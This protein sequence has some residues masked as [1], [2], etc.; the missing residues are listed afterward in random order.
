MGNDLENF[1]TSDSA[2]KMI[3]FVSD[4]FYDT[5]YVGKWLY[6]IMG[7]EYDA[8]YEM[9]GSLTDQLFPETAT[10]GLA[11][12]ELKWGLPVK[13]SVSDVER[14]KLI[15]QKRDVKKSMT[16]YQM[17]LILSYLYDCKA[18]VYD[19]HDL[20]DSE[21]APSHPNEFRVIIEPEGEKLD[22]ETITKKIK[23]LKQ[24]HTTCNISYNL[25]RDIACDEYYAGEV[26]RGRTRRFL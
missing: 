1:P 12:H 15:Y 16:P 13:E 5:S 14:R 3:S 22:A 7:Q 4:G 25:I 2:K 24:S 11:F 9:V 8:A 6:Q 23:G 21:F 18:R 19:I 26:A 10:W 20:G 17:E